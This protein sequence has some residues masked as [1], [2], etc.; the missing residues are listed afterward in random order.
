MDFQQPSP[1]HE[2]RCDHHAAAEALRGGSSRY[3]ALALCSISKA[4]IVY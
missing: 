3:V 4:L 2:P 1:L